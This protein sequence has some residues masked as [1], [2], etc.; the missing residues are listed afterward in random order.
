MT[1]GRPSWLSK[2]L[3]YEHGVIKV[4]ILIVSTSSTDQSSPN[5]RVGQCEDFLCCVAM[6]SNQSHVNS[7]QDIIVCCSRLR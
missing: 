1:T 3:I 7:Q 5:T 2:P 4:P 6:R